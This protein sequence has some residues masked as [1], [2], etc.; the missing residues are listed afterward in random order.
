[1]IISWGLKRTVLDDQQS[2]ET[3]YISSQDSIEELLHKQGVTDSVLRPSG[4]AIIEKKRY[5]V[6][7]EGSVVE[8]NTPVKVVKVEA[9]QIFVRPIKAK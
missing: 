9:N 8:K 4:F 5:D 6:M 2:V 7:S 1:M 3:G